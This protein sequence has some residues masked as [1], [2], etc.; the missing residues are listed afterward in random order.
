MLHDVGFAVHFLGRFDQQIGKRR[1]QRVAR[2][3]LLGR[4]DHLD[5]RRRQ[6]LAEVE[7]AHR[8]MDLRQVRKAPRIRFSLREIV[9]LHVGCAVQLAHHRWLRGVARQEGRV[10]LAG[11]QRLG[12]VVAGQRQQ[13]GGAARLDAVCLEQGQRQFAR[14][15]ALGADRKAQALEFRQ[16]RGGAAVI[17]DRERHV[18]HAAE[19]HQPVRYRS[20]GDAVL[21]EAHVDLAVRIGEAH[22]VLGRTLGGQY[23]EGNAVKREDCLVLLRGIPERAALGTGS[24]GQRVGRRGLDQ[25]HGHPDGDGGDQNDR[26]ERHREIAPGDGH[27]TGDETG[28]FAAGGRLHGLT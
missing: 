4:R 12:G 18:G 27:E 2:Y 17:E 13:G 25:A 6:V 11:D 3:Q 22:E 10:D 8:Q 15:A 20:G 26:T 28:R 23:V 9:E 21:H 16:P 7:G 5:R 1:V 24:D 14:A 19:R